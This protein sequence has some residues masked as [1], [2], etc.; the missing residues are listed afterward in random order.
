MAV[1]ISASRFMAP[2]YGSSSI[3]WTVIIGVILVAM[4]IGNLL[5]GILADRP[6]PE[7]TLYQLIWWA[8]IWIALI[9]IA[10]KYLIVLTTG[11]FLALFPG[12]IIVVGSLFSCL[13]LFAFPCLVLGAA[14]P[15]VIKVATRD[16][17]NN[18]RVSGEIYGLS[19]LGSIIGTF[20]P[21][22]FTIPLV[23]TAKTFFLFAAILNA[24]AV[25]FYFRGSKRFKT[26]AVTLILTAIL[27]ISPMTH[28]YAFWD[29]AI[30]ETESVYN[31]LLVKDDQYSRTLSTHVVIG[32]QSMLQKG[33]VLTG[34]YYDLAVLANYFRK[35]AFSGKSFDA[36]VLGF[37]TGTYARLSR[38]FLP[39]C[40]VD[41]VEIDPEIV[42]LGRKYFGLEETGARVFI[43]DGRIFLSRN[44]KKYQVIFLD[45]FQDVTY[46]FHMATKEF[47]EKVHKKLVGEGFLVVNVNLPSTVK[48]NLCTYVGET[49]KSVFPKV[50]CCAHPD[51][52]NQVIFA[53][54][55]MDCLETWKRNMELVPRDHLL[56]YLF[57]GA[58]GHTTEVTE[59]RL[60][61]TDDLAPVE[62]IGFR[63]LQNLIREGFREFAVR[64]IFYLKDY[65]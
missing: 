30:S 39:E 35:D 15:C 2:Y 58:V 20:L 62:I 33:S 63:V 38:K 10:G 29:T 28:S 14:S 7:K 43:D 45:A 13:S 59:S 1:E 41:G 40:S 21:T 6:D 3:T 37:G 36:L 65:I 46:P 18:G 56:A 42:N 49:I 48:P 53:G 54:K 44:D 5:G 60:V 52:F 23:G 57:Q 22:F 32:V 11:I 64:G 12:Q 27:L 34:L 19:T 31:Y 8:S 16:L 55:K 24:L 17:E 4:S 61:F 50:F 26:Q 51:Y 47:V 9:P 25:I